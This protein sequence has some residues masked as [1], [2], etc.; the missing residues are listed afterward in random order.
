MH[1]LS[2]VIVVT[3]MNVTLPITMHIGGVFYCSSIQASICMRCRHTN[4]LSMTRRYSNWSFLQRTKCKEKLLLLD[5]EFTVDESLSL[6][7]Q[8]AVKSG[9][10]QDSFFVICVQS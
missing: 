3:F 5:N 6:F 4:I 8:F 10:V 7:C 9:I 1:D 2:A